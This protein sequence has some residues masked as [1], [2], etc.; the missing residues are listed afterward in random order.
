MFTNSNNI[1]M[2]IPQKVW[3]IFIFL[4]SINTSWGQQ[5]IEIHTAKKIYSANDSFDIIECFVTQKG[6]IQFTGNL[7]SA[8]K[9]FPDAT[10]VKHNGYI[11]PGF[12]DAHCH[13]LAY[14]RGTE[15]L[16]L[17]GTSSKIEVRKKLKKFACKNKKR[18]W[19]I[20]RGWDQNN[21]EVQEFPNFEDLNGATKIPTCLS[22]V[23]GHAIWLNKAALDHLKLNYDTIITGGEILKLSNGKAS[24]V[25]IDNAADWIQDMIP[26]MNEDLMIKAL[27][28]G[29]EDLL[30]SGITSISEAGLSYKEIQ[31]I[32]NQQTNGALP[33]RVNAMLSVNQENLNHISRNDI[34]QSE[35]L[36]VRSMKFYLDGALGSRGAL[37]KHDYCDRVHHKGLQLMNANEFRYYCTYLY[38]KNYQACVHAIGD[39]ANKIVIDVFTKILAPDFD[40]RWRIEHAQVVDINDIGKLH[41]YGV[42][43]SIQPTHA[44]SDAP[45]AF[46]RICNTNSNY[47]PKNGAYAY[48]TWLDSM[49]YVALGTDFPVEGISPIAT[50][51]SSVFR[52]D[53]SGNLKQAFLPQQCLSRKQTLLG[54]TLWAAHAE[55]TDDYKGSIEIGKYADFVVLNKDIME[56]EESKF[57]SVKVKH[58][59][60]DGKKVR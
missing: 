59:Y 10:L 28:C 2:T 11:Y 26:D 54:M 5:T 31:F 24:G 9:T 57:N 13:F 32:H 38:Q 12:N 40:A 20:G 19:I 37:L 3:K 58:T 46:D 49:G 29:T 43:P 35:K 1:K 30:K 50:F 39:S 27:K 52:K 16:Q 45:W 41:N 53:L 56:I 34:P 48:K 33:I 60:I 47:N 23:D 36:R 18:K 7:D 8:K 15:E 17:F 55:F 22:R 42:I 4:F 14:C 25:F 21:W 51:Y 44:T 6:I